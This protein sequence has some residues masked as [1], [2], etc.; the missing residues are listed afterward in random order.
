VYYPEAAADS[1]LV[2]LFRPDAVGMEVAGDEEACGA[3]LSHLSEFV[4]G[5]EGLMLRPFLQVSEHK[6]LI[7]FDVI[8]QNCFLVGITVP[9]FRFI[10]VVGVRV[11]GEGLSCLA[12]AGESVVPDVVECCQ[13]REGLRTVGVEVDC[14]FYLGVVDYCYDAVFNGLLCAHLDE[15]FVASG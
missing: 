6:M 15:L 8:D 3:D 14:R 5:R 13:V 9:E 2:D 1:E 4:F 11:V 12:D 7:F 10:L